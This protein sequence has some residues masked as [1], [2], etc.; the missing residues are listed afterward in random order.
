MNL[1]TMLLILTN[2]LLCVR[3]IFFS[4]RD[5]ACSRWG[6]RV[7]LYLVVIFMAKQVIYTLHALGQHT[8]PG[9]V[10]FHIGLLFV[11][12]IIRPEHL[13]WNCSYESTKQSYRRLGHLLTGSWRGIWSPRLYGRQTESRPPGH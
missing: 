7:A 4:G 11:S 13:P 3:L 5:R 6:Y 1:W 9:V 12:M 8:Y 2:S 10:V